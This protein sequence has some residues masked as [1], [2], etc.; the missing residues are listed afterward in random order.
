MNGGRG[1]SY[2]KRAEHADIVAAVRHIDCIVRPGNNWSLITEALYSY[3]AIAD[4]G[5]DLA[6]ELYTYAAEWLP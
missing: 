5:V 1:A 3:L 2:S 6:F 4:Y